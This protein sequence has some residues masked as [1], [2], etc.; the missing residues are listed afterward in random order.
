MKLWA[1]QTRKPFLGLAVAAMLGIFA[2]D[3]WAL[4]LPW[5][6]GVAVL[7]LLAILVRPSTFT[8]WLFCAAVFFEL[9]TL[10]RWNSDARWLADVLAQGPRVVHATGIVWSEPEKPVRWSGNVTS[11]F[12]V[13]LESLSIG[14]ATFATHSL[15]N[16]GWAGEMP[17]YGDRVTFVGGAS[18][19]EPRR[20][21]GEFD[22][23]S[24]QQRLGVYSEIRARFATDCR[25]A[26]HGHG[27]PLQ[28]VAL[29]TR[30]W[31]QRHL[32]IDLAD[33][34]EVVAIIDG[35][36]LGL[37]GESPEDLKIL[38]QRTGTIHLFVV[39]GLNIAMLATIVFFA[40]K[41]FGL[42]RSFNIVAVILL[43]AAY[44]LITGMRTSSVRSTIMATL[45][46]GASLVDRRA[47]SVNSLAAAALAI[48]AFDTNELF[49]PGF[50]FSFTLVFIIIV[51]AAPIQRWLEVFA[52]PDPFLP[53]LLW[54]WP[55]KCRTW[56]WHRVCVALG[57]V[58]A[59][60]IGSLLFTVGYFHLFSPG[61]LAANFL[62]V[63]IAFMVLA[64]GLGSILT[65]AISLH[66]TVL[67]NN[68]NWFAARAMLFVLHASANL[69][70]GFVYVENPRT[71]RA[72]RCE[73]T[74]LDLGEGG[75]I[76]VR[77]GGCDWLLDCGD[78]SRY[79]HTVLPYL[80]SRG[81]NRLDGL[82]L[83]HGNVK[84]IGAGV[85]AIGDFHPYLLAESTQ[86][87]RSSTRRNLHAWLA[88]HLL[89]K[90]LYMRDDFIRLGHATSLRVLY[91]PAGLKRSAAGDMALV[92]Q[93]ES[94]G[95]R[96]L[97]MSASG[98]A[99]EQWLL[100]NEP[101]LHADILIKGQHTKDLS[102]TP[103]FLARVAPRVVICSALG[104]G[105]PIEKLDAWE[106]DAASQGAA[107]FR[108]DKAGAAHIDIRDD[109]YEVRGFVNGQTFR[110]RAR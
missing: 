87:D 70:N 76:H 7:G 45:L 88:Q 32:E 109:G 42:P 55:V 61:S 44:T 71:T 1:S 77:A 102:G 50:Q 106:T 79:N 15:A 65:A 6:F 29:R 25:V 80:R 73:L 26:S 64:L 4:T 58:L 37:R 10:H 92:V 17:A 74:V 30:H 69:P 33:S 8:C 96:A 60:W 27:N 105:E 38:L 49:A 63:P 107:V 67:F 3:R 19:L 13:K 11:R 47:I 34:P 85:T 16:V 86:K 72:P 84:H 36:V 46:L 91:P 9:H 95:T 75:A 12:V 41:P 31:V 103:D 53:R 108:Q 97:L 21:P 62:A 93:L 2:A 52:Q 99:T 28:A 20:N 57:V 100:E 98:F 5:V 22:S 18:N 83:S 66:A 51:C 94:G 89:G 101:D 81:V 43:L 48:L 23:T 56:C 14:G 40:L 110:N 78:D 82:L 68:A 59:S 39:S 90:G 54:S 35:I 104:Y 24:Y